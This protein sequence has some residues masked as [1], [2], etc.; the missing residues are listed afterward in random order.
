MN[1]WLNNT[2]IYSIDVRLNTIALSGESRSLSMCVTDEDRVFE[3]FA[4]TALTIYLKK[5][6]NDKGN[7]D[8]FTRGEIDAIANSIA[9]K[10]HAILEDEIQKISDKFRE[11]L[12][13][14][15]FSDDFIDRILEKVNQR[16]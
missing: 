11:V 6:F 9:I 5:S 7:P 14:E 4:K 3:K 16:R 15:G 12:R 10:T 2:Q 8:I 13:L 1:S